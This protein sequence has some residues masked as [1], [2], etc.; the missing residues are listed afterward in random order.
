[1]VERDV[2]SLVAGTPVAAE[3]VLALEDEVGPAV[4]RRAFRAIGG[5]A[6]A[7]V[8]RRLA[9]LPGGEYRQQG[10]VEFDEEAFLVRCRLTVRDGALEF[11]Y[12]G[13]SPQCPY[14]FNSNPHIVRAAP[15]VR[16]HPVHPADAP[17]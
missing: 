6:A 5:L 13:S 16:G 8:Q 14:F 15:A 12:A 1:T 2:K 4:L 10:W 9:A 7:V 11:D 17:Y 3:Q